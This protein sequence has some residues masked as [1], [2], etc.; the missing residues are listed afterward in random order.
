MFEIGFWELVVVGI[1]AL[2]AFGPSKLPAI[3][4][5]LA[6][7]LI[8]AKNSIQTIKNEF[9]QEIQ[10]TSDSIESLEKKNIQTKSDSGQ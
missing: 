8:R 10:R 6:R 9:E 5:V 7:Y 1:V 4:R 2:W 3:T